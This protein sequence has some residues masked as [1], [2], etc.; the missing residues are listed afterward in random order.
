[1]TSILDRHDEHAEPVPA[2]ER[3]TVALTRRSTDYLQRLRDWSGLSK[4]DLVNRALSVYYFVAQQERDGR[5][6]ALYDPQKK[7]FQLVHVVS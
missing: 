7:E 4:T 3:I 1:M 6:L 2:A 5:Q